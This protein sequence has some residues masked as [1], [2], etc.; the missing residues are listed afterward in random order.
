MT[1]QEQALILVLAILGLLMVVLSRT[2]TWRNRSAAKRRLEATTDGRGVDP[3]EVIE[4]DDPRPVFSRYWPLPFVV[5]VAVAI[6]IRFA[7]GLHF[8]YALSIGLM[9]GTLTWLIQDLTHKKSISRFENQLADVVD[10]IVAA[11][12]AGSSLAD[13][14]MTAAGEVRDP[15]RSEIEDI[16]ERIRLGEDPNQALTMMQERVPLESFRLFGFTLASHW[17]GGGSLAP[18]LSSVG[19]T[20]RDRIQLYDRIRSQAME[21]QLSVYVV[22]VISYGLGYMLYRSDVDR[23]STFL[24]SSVGVGAVSGSLVLQTVGLF[25][26]HSMTKIET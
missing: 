1:E 19:R 7:M 8:A 4:I 9:S 26:M 11:L 14:M 22:L 5:F 13:A 24:A 20:I 17:G 12:R 21:A 6:L 23:A 16:V 25:W 3:V 2:R 15:L 18:T 10:L